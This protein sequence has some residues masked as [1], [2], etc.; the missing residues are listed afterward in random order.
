[1]HKKGEN[2]NSIAELR[3]LK[4]KKSQG[5]EDA[6]NILLKCPEIKI[7]REEFACSKGKNVHINEDIALTQIIRCTDVTILNCCNAFL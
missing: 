6:R 7:L 2:A 4:A 3:H 5:E 1:M